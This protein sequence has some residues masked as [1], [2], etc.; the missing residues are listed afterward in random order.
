MPPEVGLEGPVPVEALLAVAA[1]VGP[2]GRGSRGQGLPR[3]PRPHAVRLDVTLPVRLLREAFAT[4][5][6][7]EWLLTWG[8]GC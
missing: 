3:A 4:D 6:T 7:S 5:G 8:G 2:G 1:L